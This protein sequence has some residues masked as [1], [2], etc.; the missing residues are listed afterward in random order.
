ME[1]VAMQPTVTTA[2][3]DKRRWTRQEYAQMGDL[4]WFAGQRVELIDGDIMVLSPQ[5]FGHYA[6]VDRVAEVLRGAFG[7]GFWVR[8]Q[9][10]MGFGAFSEPEPDV[11]VVTGRRED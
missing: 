7:A 5:K 8:T 3:P 11:S 9:A 6:A 1:G 4:G 2:E 10:P